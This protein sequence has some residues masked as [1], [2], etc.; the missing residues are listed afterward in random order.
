M[1]VLLLQT[2][3]EIRGEVKEGCR[4]GRTKRVAHQDQASKRPPPKLEI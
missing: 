4:E 3:G 2:C 1:V